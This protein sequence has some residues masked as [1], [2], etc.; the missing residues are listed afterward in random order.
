MAGDLDNLGAVV[1]TVGRTSRLMD[2][3]AYYREL[4]EELML[5][6]DYRRE[7]ELCNAFARSVE[8][9]PHLCVPRA[10]MEYTASRVLTLELLEGPT[11]KDWVTR[12]Q[13][14]EERFRVSRLLTHAILGPFLLTGEI[15]A[16][17]HPGNFL[18][19]GD[20][21]LGLLD[22]GAIKR[23]SPRFVEAHRRMFVMALRNEPVDAL[24]L[25]REV[26]FTVDLPDAEARPLLHEILE[27]AGRPIRQV[28]Y[29]Y[30]T[31]TITPD[32][33][34]HF[35]QNAGGLLRIRP[36]AEAVQFF[37]ATG[38]LTQNLRLV[39]ARGDF[40]AVHQELMDLL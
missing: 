24:A 39:G 5:E 31:C 40:R 8:R 33:K 6:L 1:K 38:G 13:T 23:F 9:L 37:R 17:P 29:D 2:G 30:A 3:T 26:G 18:V 4:R 12:E 35:A 34:R 22:F 27:I 36:P 14:P 21:R 15:H 11:L 16:D 28:P 19:M 32:M 25:V 10:V 7:A 20:G